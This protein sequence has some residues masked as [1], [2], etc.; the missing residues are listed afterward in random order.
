MTRFVS[1]SS[2]SEAEAEENAGDGPE[3]AVVDPERRARKRLKLRR[4]RAAKRR[5]KVSLK[6]SFFQRL[7]RRG[8]V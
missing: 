7:A 5:G 4:H 3:R 2:E 8:P 6:P 1:L